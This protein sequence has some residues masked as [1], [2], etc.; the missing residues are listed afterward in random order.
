MDLLNVIQEK[1]NRD[2]EILYSIE[3]YL[4]NLDSNLIKSKRQNK[5]KF[6]KNGSRENYTLENRKDSKPKFR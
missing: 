6:K 2:F 1:V 4:L 3:D 5:R